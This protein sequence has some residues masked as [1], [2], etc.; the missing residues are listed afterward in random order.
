MTGRRDFFAR[1]WANPCGPP[2]A[3]EATV[4]KPFSRQVTSVFGRLA[5]ASNDGI[6]DYW[7]RQTSP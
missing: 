6:V 4:L 5:Q 2:E 3:S 7:K 1:S